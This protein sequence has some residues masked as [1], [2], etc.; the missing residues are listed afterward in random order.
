M[1]FYKITTR[2]SSYNCVIKETKNGGLSA[3][4]GGDEYVCLELVSNDLDIK[5]HAE[6]FINVGDLDVKAKD[7]MYALL[8][9]L[10][11][12]HIEL[13]EIHLT[14]MSHNETFGNLASYYLAFYQ[15]TW[16]ERDFCA[17][18]KNDKIRER[19]E[20]L[21]KGFKTKKTVPNE[22]VRGL[23]N[24]FL[25]ETDIELVSQLYNTST[26]YEEFFAN[27]KSSGSRD[28]LGDLVKPW[29]EKFIKNKDFLGFNIINLETW[30]I[31]CDKQQGCKI[32]EMNLRDKD[33]QVISLENDPYK[34]NYK[35]IKL[36]MEQERR[37]EYEG[38]IGGSLITLSER[39]K[40]SFQNPRW[41]GWV[42]IDINTYSEADRKYLLDLNSQLFN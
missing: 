5:K 15:Q 36:L 9:I 2:Q 12:R 10:K 42:D 3:Y 26:T 7:M 28:D 24:A 41:I 14:D 8:Y 25:N 27:L 1:S 31:Y 29:L 13:C 35:N 21:Q 11:T 20:E 6:C 22:G 4:L 16:Y 33:F 19:Y 39:Q 40:R 30:I 32:D 37:N 38:Q 23:L 18:L 17:Y 34:G